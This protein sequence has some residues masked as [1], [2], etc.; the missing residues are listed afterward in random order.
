MPTLV[1]ARDRDAGMPATAL[2]S[3]RR[4]VTGDLYGLVCPV[5]PRRS[6]LADPD[7]TAAATRGRRVSTQGTRYE[8]RLTKR[9]ALPLAKYAVAR[10]VFSP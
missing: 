3:T 2:P 6:E 5:M 1:S 10:R 4:S 9:H 7:E 8:Q